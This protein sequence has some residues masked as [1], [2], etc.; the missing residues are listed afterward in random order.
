MLGTDAGDIVAAGGRDLSPAQRAMLGPGET[1]AKLPGAHAE[2]T[3]LEGAAQAGAKP[4][5]LG[6]SRPICDACKATIEESGGTLT[7]P[8]TAVWEQ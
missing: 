3:A 6:V 7:S 4:Q 5:A 8:T 1:A 2:V